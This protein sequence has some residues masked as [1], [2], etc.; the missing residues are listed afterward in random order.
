MVFLK[1]AKTQHDEDFKMRLKQGRTFDDYDDDDDDANISLKQNQNIL[2]PS[3][4]WALQ[5]QLW[6]SLGISVMKKR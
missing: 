6:S 1:Q 4:P 5:H 3:V 2:L